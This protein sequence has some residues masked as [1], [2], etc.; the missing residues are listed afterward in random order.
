[1]IRYI[2]VRSKTDDIAS[3]V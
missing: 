2:S 3:L 1:M